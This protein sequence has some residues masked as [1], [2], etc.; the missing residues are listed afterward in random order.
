[1]P[2]IAAPAEN[3]TVPE[4]CFPIRAGMAATCGL[5]CIAAK[6]DLLGASGGAE[7]IDTA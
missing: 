1:L 5:A 2:V 3:Q 7:Q 4:F 6:R